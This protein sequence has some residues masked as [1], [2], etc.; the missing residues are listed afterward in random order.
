M[1]ANRDAD[2]TD[3]WPDSGGQKFNP[4]VMPA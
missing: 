1:A 2:M 3:R 4:D